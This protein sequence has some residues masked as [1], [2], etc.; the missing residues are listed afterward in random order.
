MCTSIDFSSEIIVQSLVPCPTNKGVPYTNL[1]SRLV[2]TLK[3]N[4]HHHHQKRYLYKYNFCT[5]IIVDLL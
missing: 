5:N 4:H 1:V 2:M 3:P